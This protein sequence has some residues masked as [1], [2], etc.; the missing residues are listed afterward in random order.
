MSPGQGI[1][2]SV[3]K[4]MC[5]YYCLVNPKERLYKVLVRLRVE[6]IGMCV[7]VS[8]TKGRVGVC[9]DVCLTNRSVSMVGDDTLA[10][11]VWK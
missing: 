11:S 7:D 6:Y 10:A 9:V 3:G 2:T 5:V 1:L 8:E 4:I